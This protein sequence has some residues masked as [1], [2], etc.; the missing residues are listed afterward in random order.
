MAKNDWSRRWSF[1]RM[2]AAISAVLGTGLFFV[3]PEVASNIAGPI[4]LIIASL[5]TLAGIYMGTATW[6]DKREN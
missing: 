6:D 4:S 5:T 1:M 3:P 2:I